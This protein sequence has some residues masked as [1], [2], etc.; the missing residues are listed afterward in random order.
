MCIIIERLKSYMKPFDRKIKET[1]DESLEDIAD[2]IEE[3][4]SDIYDK[5]LI[6]AAKE[7]R[8]FNTPNIET[9]DGQVKGRWKGESFNFDDDY[10]PKEF[11]DDHLTMSEIKKE[12]KKKYN[13]D[14]GDIPYK[15]EVVD[16]GDISV[17]HI[18]TDKIIE[19]ASRI[20]IDNYEQMSLRGRIR[21]LHDLFSDRDDEGN[22]QDKRNKNFR[23]A[24]EIAAESGIRIPG[25]G[26][27][28]TAD[29]LGDWRRDNHFTWDEQIE[30]GYNLVPSVIHGNLKHSGLVSHV[31]QAYSYLKHLYSDQRK[32]PEKYYFEEDEALISYD[33]IKESIEK[34]SHRKGVKK[35][36]KRKVLRNSF[37]SPNS[38]RKSI[39]TIKSELDNK[40]DEHHETIE[41]LGAQFE[42][43]K[44]KLESAIER[45]KN[46]K[47][48]ED[49]KKD[50]I[51]QLEEGIVEVQQQYDNNVGKELEA[52]RQEMQ[53][54]LD[55][56]EEEANELQ[57][58]ADELSGITMEAAN[59]DLSEIADAALSKKVEYEN[60][61]K[62]FE[63]RLLQ[64]QA[65]AAQQRSRILNKK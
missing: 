8:K 51:Q 53:N 42:I 31:K 47:I 35:M 1:N 6:I 5:E 4:L 52:I 3:E 43:D 54:H 26:V 22:K 50:M 49:A 37:D 25:L 59:V 60:V 63:D 2:R 11:N 21:L 62:E 9:E 34:N 19:K 20:S 61:K 38:D 30:G 33:E 24:D 48:D 46:S 27:H 28:Y 29:E 15:D 57:K 64:E 55:E 13:I 17:V 23:Y 40:L 45:V 7:K 41:G 39:D 14:V 36:P 12:L 16:F 44:M 65:A 32:H 56:I 10:I 58:Q 18:P